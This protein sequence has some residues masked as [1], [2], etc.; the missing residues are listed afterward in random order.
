M[1]MC[2]DNVLSP[3]DFD[4]Y[5]NISTQYSAFSMRDE[6]LE[7]SITYEDFLPQFFLAPGGVSTFG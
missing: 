7:L 6:A 3:L 1:L 5:V 2:G 4:A